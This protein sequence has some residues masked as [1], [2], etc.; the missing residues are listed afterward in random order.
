MSNKIF[1]LKCER[2]SNC[3][4]NTSKHQFSIGHKLRVPSTNNKVVF[5]KFLDDCPYFANMVTLEQQP[6]FLQLLRKVKYFNK[7]MNGN[8]WTNIS[9]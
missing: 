3:L 9:K 7:S 6:Q 5:R 8:E 4:C 1:C 2:T